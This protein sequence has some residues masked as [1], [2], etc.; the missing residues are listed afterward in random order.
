MFPKEKGKNTR[1]D[2]I[3]NIIYN[4]DYIFNTFSYTRKV[5]YVN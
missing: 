3:E 1:A 5:I 4:I 2:L